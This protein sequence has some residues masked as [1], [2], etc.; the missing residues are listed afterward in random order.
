M[1]VA[2]IDYT[3]QN[4]HVFWEDNVSGTFQIYYKTKN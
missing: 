3:T 1:P 2:Q 4:V